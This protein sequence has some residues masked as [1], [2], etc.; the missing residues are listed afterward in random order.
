MRE[1]LLIIPEFMGY[2][3]AIKKEL[4]SRFNVTLLAADQLDNSSILYFRKR[5]KI[6][7]AFRKCLPYVDSRDRIKAIEKAYRLSENTL[8]TC[9]E[10]KYDVIL[11]VNGHYIPDSIYKKLR[12]NNTASKFIL[13]LWDDAKNLFRRTHFK[14]FDRFYS[15]NIN[16]CAIYKMLYLPM[17]T[18]CMHVGHLKNMY[19]I[20]V[21]ASAHSNRLDIV[22][23]IYEKYSSKYSFYIYLYQKPLVN[24]DNEWFHDKPLDYGQYIDVLRHSR[25]LLDIQNPIQEGPTT[26]AFDVMQ[27]ETKLITTNSNI[28]NY[29]IYGENILIVNDDYIIDDTF[30][31]K[32]YVCERREVYSLKDWLNKI[33]VM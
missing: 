20:C 27:T 22:K 23:R 17:Y 10:K 2:D 31:Q 11:V 14:Y 26:R 19:D 29:P 24:I 8:D 4:D 33:E 21:I 18:Q 13:Y 16:D 12:K 9:L 3:K 1:V 28:I 5:A 25:C 7:K 15:Y 6:Y 30:V 32:E